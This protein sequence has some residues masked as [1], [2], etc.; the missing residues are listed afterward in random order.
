MLVITMNGGETTTITTPAGETIRVHILGECDTW[1][2]TRVGFDAPD[3]YLILRQDLRSRLLRQLSEQPVFRISSAHTP[4]ELMIA[5][6]RGQAENDYQRRYPGCPPIVA[7]Q[8][9]EPA[10]WPEFQQL[11]RLWLRERKPPLAIVV[12]DGR[13]E[14]LS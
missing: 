2:N 8:V 3:D 4:T 1:R 11:E 12:E 9:A 13:G 7:T 6:S 5:Y 10:D 14:G